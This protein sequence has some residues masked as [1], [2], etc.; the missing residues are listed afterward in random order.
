MLIN[1][2]VNL[3]CVCYVQFHAVL[4]TA[5]SSCATH[6]GG[7]GNTA[8]TATQTEPTDP[9][10]ADVVKRDAAVQCQL[11]VLKKSVSVQCDKYDHVYCE[12]CNQPI[13]VQPLATSTPR[14]SQRTA[15]DEN[16]YDHDDDDD[17]DI[18]DDTYIPSDITDDD[19]DITLHDHDLSDLSITATDD[20]PVEQRVNYLVMDSELKKLFRFCPQC[21][22]KVTSFEIAVIG[23]MISVSYCCTAGHASSWRSQPMIRRM[24]AANILCSAA[25]LLSG[26]T[27][28][29]ISH[30]N[31]DF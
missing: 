7:T 23:A 6:A 28:C 26:S 17:D 16:D 12:A 4:D 19:I 9:V 11:D 27:Y 1:L 20:I 29:K 15:D 31:L 14:D 18:N 25:V 2:L 24:P 5:S 21:G 8:T 30:L 3:K 13:A 10:S 22:Y